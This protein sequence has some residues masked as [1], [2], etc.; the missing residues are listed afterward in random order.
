MEEEERD[1]GNEG[2][3]ERNVDRFRDALG[4]QENKEAALE[5]ADAN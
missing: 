4:N 2:D 3:F 5:D 1:E